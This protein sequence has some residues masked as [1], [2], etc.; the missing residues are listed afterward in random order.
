MI[1]HFNA[2]LVTFHVGSKKLGSNQVAGESASPTLSL[3]C[4][5][6]SSAFNIVKFH[7]IT[8]PC[9]NSW[10]SKWLSVLNGPV[11]QLPLN[12]DFV[13]LSKIQ[14][15]QLLLHSDKNRK[16]E[17]MLQILLQLAFYGYCVILLWH[18]VSFWNQ[19]CIY[20]T[21]L[22]SDVHYDFIHPT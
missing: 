5:D 22:D 6:S 10:T 9:F 1:T 19:I 21:E 4:T 15:S 13:Q 8:H 7:Q 17:T 12:D 16:W 18:F 14:M 20:Y 3:T 11:I 2:T